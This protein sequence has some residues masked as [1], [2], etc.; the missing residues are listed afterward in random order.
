MFLIFL[1][2]LLAEILK[3]W[4]FVAQSVSDSVT[5]RSKTFCFK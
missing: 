3:S 1:S 4:C 5:S 2:V